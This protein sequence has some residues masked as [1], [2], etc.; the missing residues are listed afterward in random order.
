M[1]DLRDLRILKK[2]DTITF[3]I[4][5]RYKMPHERMNFTEYLYRSEAE[6]KYDEIKF[7]SLYKQLVCTRFNF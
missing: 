2:I 1:T 7:L 5:L 4:L 6:D 3:G